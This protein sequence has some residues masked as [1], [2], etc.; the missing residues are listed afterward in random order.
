ML[1]H[2]LQN[3]VVSNLYDCLC[4]IGASKSN[5]GKTWLAYCY[6]L[7]EEHHEAN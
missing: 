4:Y 2:N 7:K 1:V 3:K 5:Y 6:K